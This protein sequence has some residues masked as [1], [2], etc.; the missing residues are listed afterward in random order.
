M[1]A[2]CANPKC[3]APFRYL[4]TGR[5]FRVE[6]ERMTRADETRP[7]YYWLCRGCSEKMTLRLD[8]T[9]GVK[10]VVLRESIGNASEPPDLVLLDRRQGRLLNRIT[11]T[12]RRTRHHHESGE[13]GTRAYER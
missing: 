6:Y 12:G 9:G 5:L 13:E 11:F 8:E 3:A 7:E 10:L 2:K 1:L 4:E